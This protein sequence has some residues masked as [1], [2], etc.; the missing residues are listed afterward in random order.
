MVESQNWPG[1]LQYPDAVTST[2]LV[3][4][5]GGV[6]SA[7]AAWSGTPVLSIAVNCGTE[8]RRAS[9]TTGLYVAAVAAPG[10]CSITIAEPV[11]AQ[12]TVSYGLVAHYPAIRRRST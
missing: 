4:T 9:G 2:Y 10:T 12:A 6:V 11:S 7:T 5:S 8:E 3:R 1:Y